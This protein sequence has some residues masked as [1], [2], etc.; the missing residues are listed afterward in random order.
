MYLPTYTSEGAK[1]A[2]NI[3]LIIMTVINRQLQNRIFCNV[4]YYLEIERILNILAWS[5]RIT[6]DREP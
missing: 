1:N 6:R 4:Q 3:Y 2:E 5:N